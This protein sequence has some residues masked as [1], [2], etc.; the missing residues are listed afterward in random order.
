M[1][2]P[3]PVEWHQVW[4]FPTAVTTLRAHPDKY[5]K[6]FDSVVIFLTQYINKKAQT[7]IVKVV[8]V[9]E[10]WHAKWQKTSTTLVTFKGKIELKKYSREE[11]N[12]MSMVQCQQL[13]ELHK[14]AGLIKGKKTPESSRV[15][16]SR[17]ATLVE[18]TDNSSN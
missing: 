1:E 16:E 2:S 3:I 18:N 17:V 4:Q 13:Y 9:A 6:Y 7:P 12:S 11:Y 10:A 5:K 15:L 14:K 8:S